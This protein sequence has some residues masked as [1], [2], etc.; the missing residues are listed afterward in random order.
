MVVVPTPTDPA[1]IRTNARD[2]RT[3]SAA[4]KH[5][6]EERGGRRNAGVTRPVAGG[7]QLPAR[8]KILRATFEASILVERTIY[9]NTEVLLYWYFSL[10]LDHFW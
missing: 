4:K 7:G 3:W 6:D 9:Q 8:S 1:G 5:T 10:N 2:L